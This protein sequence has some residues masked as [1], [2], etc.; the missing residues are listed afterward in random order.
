MAMSGRPFPWTRQKA[1]RL[2]GWRICSGSTRLMD[3]HPILNGSPSSCH[4]RALTEAPSTI[5]DRRPPAA[6]TPV[7]DHKTGRRNRDS[8]NGPICTT[9][10]PTNTQSAHHAES[11]IWRHAASEGGLRTVT[12]A[13]LHPARK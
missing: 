10:S 5:L 4:A 6:V 9:S 7:Q 12:G 2:F 3:A 8:Q 1:G 13:G 11:A